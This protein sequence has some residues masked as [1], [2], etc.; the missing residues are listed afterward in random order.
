M[1]NQKY[2]EMV[3]AGNFPSDIK[4]PLDS[5]FEDVRGKIQNILL[6]PITSVAIITSKAN[7]VRSN[8]YHKTDW[9]YLY[10]VSGSM[11][12]YERDVNGEKD[13]HAQ[14]I[15]VKVG[16]MVFTSPMKI[17]KT[18]FLEDTVLLS[19]AKNVRDHEH[20]EEDVVRVEF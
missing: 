4:V 10:V 12:Y 14:P 19:L 20:H 11:L 15:L 2:S 3:Q 5:P 16:E 8:H 6:S 17:H 13:P 9:H 18:E 7:T 1:K